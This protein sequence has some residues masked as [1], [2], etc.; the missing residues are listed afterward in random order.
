MKVNLKSEIRSLKKIGLGSLHHF[1]PRK[2]EVIFLEI[3]RG[4]YWF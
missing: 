1:E 2:S 3:A 4:F